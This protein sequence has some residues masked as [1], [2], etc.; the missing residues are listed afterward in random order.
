[1]P[2]A[3]RRS[4]RPPWLRALRARRAGFRRGAGR[5]C[6]LKSSGGSPPPSSLPRSLG[7]AQR[8][9]SSCGV[10]RPAAPAAGPPPGDEADCR[11]RRRN[12]RPRRRARA[13]APRPC[14]LVRSGRAFRRPHPHGRCHARRPH[15]R[16]RHRLSRLQPAHLPQARRPVRRARRHNSGRR[17]VVLGP[18]SSGPDRV[19]QRGRRRRLR[20][21]L[22]PAAP[23]VLEHARRD[24]PL[25]PPRHRAR[26]R[27]RAAGAGL[28][29]SIGDFLD[30]HRFSTGFRD[31]YF[32]PM[33]G[34]HLVL[35]DRADAALPGRD[36]GALLRRPRPA[37]GQGPAAVVHG[38]RRRL[39]LRRQDAGCDPRCPPGDAG[40]ES[41][42]PADRRRRGRDRPGK[43]AL[44]RR[45]PRLPQRPGTRA[46]RRPE[47]RRTRGPRRDAAGSAIEPSSTATPASCPSARPPGQRG[48]TSDRTTQRRTRRRSA[49]TTSSTGSSRCPPRP[50]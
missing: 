43:R 41:Q 11:R 15:L 17:H 10:R 22:Q 4:R 8:L 7:G 34:S 40:E 32:L 23:G 38:A 50:R 20:A 31:W 6:R 36:D 39:E 35:P 26:A 16:R 30:A 9:L 27:R 33:V 46:P 24:R 13:L 48:T 12:R 49:C 25:Q 47:R 44:R 29:D 42:A 21:A 2:A 5:R 45:R 1:M 28:D 14:H 37:A 18:D 19:E 3:G